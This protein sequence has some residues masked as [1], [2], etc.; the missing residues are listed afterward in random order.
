MDRIKQITI[1]DPSYQLKSEIA[2]VSISYKKPSTQGIISFD[3]ESFDLVTCFGVLHH[4]ANVSFVI[5]EI[6]RVLRKDHYALIREPAITMGDW[7]KG[8]PGLTP[9]ER[10]IPEALMRQ[11]I[12]KAG[13]EV[14]SRTY[15]DFAP[16]IKMGKVL[17]LRAVYNSPWLTWLD[18]LASRL[19]SWNL[20][21]HRTNV[22]QKI[23]PA[24]IFWVCRKL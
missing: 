8:R 23:A 21:Y 3:D 17:R 9:R 20:R 15:C 12:E 13:L 2:G 4:I 5:S 14:V 16:I 22:F 7:R 6:G 24:S 19:F 11:A 18:A 10:G 1:L